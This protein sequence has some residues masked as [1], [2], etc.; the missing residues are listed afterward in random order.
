MSYLKKGRMKVNPSSFRRILVVEDNRDGREVLRTL[1]ELLGNQV[2]TA[3]DGAEGVLKA[4]AFQPDIALI[5]I[6]LPRL[7]GYQVARRLRA[8]LGNRVILLAQT[9]Y[10]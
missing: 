5:D 1:L 8:A 7:D 2:E 10:G 3:A 9:G 4:L 6:G